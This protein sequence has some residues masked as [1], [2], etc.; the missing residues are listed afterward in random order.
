MRFPQPALSLAAIA[1]V[2]PL[3][4]AQSPPA[5]PDLTAERAEF[6]R[7]LE[8]SRVSPFRAVYHQ[9]FHDELVFG[10]EGDPALAGLPAARLEQD[11]L[12][13]TLQ[14]ADGTRG[15]PRNRD[16]GLG[17]YVLRVSGER[18]R[19]VVTVFGPRPR[20]VGL[21]GWYPA[22]PALVIEG[23][24][25]RPAR[26][27]SRRML[28]LD[29]IE[30]EASL[31]GALV[32]RLGDR[33]IRLT[34][35]RMPEPGTEESELMVFFRDSTNGSG[36]YPAGRFLALVPLGG[37]RYRADFNRA[38]NPFCAYN[39]IFPCPLPWAGNH[40]DTPVEAGERYR[41]K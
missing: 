10:P 41:N 37:D 16:V 36:T 26:P 34:V 4:A 20:E 28:G 3:C 35:F 5:P 13:L 12:R 17:G 22:A 38:R 2:P 31:A 40:L 27:E 14:T 30:V 1:L 7:W 39:G 19:S 21:P 9:P 33:P 18:S 25:E 15:V 32:A 6:A 11:L 8:T 29:G 23:T 24:L